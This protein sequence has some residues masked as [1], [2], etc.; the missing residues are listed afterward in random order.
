[1]TQ[2]WIVFSAFRP[3]PDLGEA[4]RAAVAEVDERVIVVDDG[5]GDG[6]AGMWDELERIGAR[7]LRSADNTGIAAALNRGI[8]AALASGA[9]AVLTFDQDSTMTPGFVAALQAALD[10]AAASGIAAAF[11]VPEFF[12]GVSQVHDRSDGVLRVRHSIQSGMLVPRETFDRVG[13]LREDLFIDLVDTEF[14]LRCTVAGLAGVA[15]PGLALGHA[16]GRQYA[17]ELFGRRVRLPGIPDVVTLSSPFRYYYR[18]RNRRVINR[19][20][21]RRAPGW[22]LRDTALEAIHFANALMIARPRRAL[23]ALYR[24]GWRD[25]G[26]RRGGPMPPALQQVAATIVWDAPDA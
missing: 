9:T 25:A 8:R 17:R 19:E 24:A 22:V 3:D 26:R 10:S 23:F 12:A 6:W 5:S 11:A 18:V 7:V 15:A 14:E 16:L 13:L 1:M 21:L 4:V 2:T 20:F